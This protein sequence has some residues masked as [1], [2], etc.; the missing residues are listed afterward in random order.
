MDKNGAL[1][2]GSEWCS[3]EEP[4]LPIELKRPMMQA[5]MADRFGLKVHKETREMPVYALVVEKKGVKLTQHESGEQQVGSGN[6]SLKAKKIGMIWFTEWL[7][8][9]SWVAW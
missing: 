6:G 4:W 5:L 2:R 3:S 9:E 7:S 8:T 1:G